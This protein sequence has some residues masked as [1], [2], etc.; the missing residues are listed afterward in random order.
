MDVRFE[1]GFVLMFAQ[2]QYTPFTCTLH[3]HIYKDAAKS[4]SLFSLFLLAIE[5]YV[6]FADLLLL[7]SFFG[8]IEFFA[9]VFLDCFILYVPPS[10]AS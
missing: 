9:D 3:I 1:P 2:A 7:F 6:Y 10:Y 5:T 4:V 8:L